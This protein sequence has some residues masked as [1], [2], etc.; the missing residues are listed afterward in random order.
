MT[1]T[2]QRLR[3][4]RR[5]NQFSFR[6]NTETVVWVYY[7]KSGG[8]GMGEYPASVYVVS[9]SGLVLYTNDWTDSVSVI[10]DRLTGS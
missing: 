4:L 10:E 9:Q 8:A 1:M 5:G 6:Q 7:G 2:V 3:Q